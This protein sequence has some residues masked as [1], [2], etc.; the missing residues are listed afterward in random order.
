MTRSISWTLN[1]RIPGGPPISAA[2]LLEI[3]AYERTV[4]TL[5]K[6]ATDIGVTL[7]PDVSLLV[8]SAAQYG[9]EGD[10]SQKLTL[11]FNDGPDSFD[12]SM[13]LVVIGKPALSKFVGKK[14]E[15]IAFTSTLTKDVSIEILTARDATP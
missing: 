15:K 3:E 13:P 5:A 4:V 8:V 1:L 6:G 10:A 12:F 11:K 7:P 9:S 2:A 14:L